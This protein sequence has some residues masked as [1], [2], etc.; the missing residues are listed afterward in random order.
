MYVSL[1]YM[2]VSLAGITYMYVYV[3]HI[4]MCIYMCVSPAGILYV[5]GIIYMYVYIYVCVSP[6]GILYVCVTS[7]YHMYMYHQQD[8]I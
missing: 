4:C 3:L 7:G 8:Y 5:C 1:S 2:Y 6:A